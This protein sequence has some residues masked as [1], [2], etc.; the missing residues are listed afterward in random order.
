MP[1]IASK[2]TGEGSGEGTRPLPR[3][4]IIILIKTTFPVPA[5]YS[6]MSVVLPISRHTRADNDTPASAVV[7][8][9][10]LPLLYPFHTYAV[11]AAF[12]CG[13][14]TAE[15]RKNRKYTAR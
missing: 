13:S 9:V 3:I 6:L 1:V 12:L 7:S 8:A 14:T 10:V 5:V 11:Q 15:N 2:T 4:K